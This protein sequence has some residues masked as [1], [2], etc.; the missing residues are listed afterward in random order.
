M[1]AALD[2]ILIT[3]PL[4]RVVAANRAAERLLGRNTGSLLGTP[5][6]EVLA[7]AVHDELRQS[8]AQC[9]ATGDAPLLGR[10]VVSSAVRADGRRVPVEFALISLRIGGPEHFALFLRAVGPEPG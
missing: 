1:E 7:P 9:V 5:V 8:L 4:G 6:L 3:D 2:C 10:H